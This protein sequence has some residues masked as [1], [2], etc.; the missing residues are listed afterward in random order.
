MTVPYPTDRWRVPL[1][2]LVAAA[3]VLVVHATHW[4]LAVFM[5]TLGVLDVLTARQPDTQ[6]KP[7]PKLDVDNV[8]QYHAP[9]GDQP[10][11]YI[12][13]REKAKE[14]AVLIQTTT[15]ESR[16]QSVAL[17]NLQQTVMWANA[18]IAINE[19]AETV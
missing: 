16:E 11:R 2:L 6:E 17:T 1:M 19:H 9:H 4:R 5:V 8:F 7:M 13:L 12:A 3:Y 10:Q 18:A 14:L 15:P